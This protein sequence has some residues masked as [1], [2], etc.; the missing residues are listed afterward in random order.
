MSPSPP[1]SPIAPTLTIR[2]AT[3]ADLPALGRLG[4][5][6]V[7]LHEFAA[8]LGMKRE[9]FQPNGKAPHYDLT[10]ARRSDALKLGAV[11]VGAKE[12]ARQRKTSLTMSDTVNLTE[13]HT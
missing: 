3:R 7:R 4:A 8:Q 9:W 10:P 1:P 2:R 5:N 6:L 12:Q 13:E 11:F